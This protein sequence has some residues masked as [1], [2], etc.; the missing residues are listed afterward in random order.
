MNISIVELGTLPTPDINQN[1]DRDY[2]TRVVTRGVLVP[3]AKQKHAVLRW[4]STPVKLS[5]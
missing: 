5:L 1:E 4:N 3:H 2:H